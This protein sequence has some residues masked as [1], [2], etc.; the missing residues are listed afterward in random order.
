M[1]RKKIIATLGPSSLKK[2][3][4]EKMDF[5]GVDIFRLNLSHVPLNE[6]E[7]TL[8]MVT[9]WTKKTVC[10]DSEGAQLRTG[11][12]KEKK[13]NLIK[14]STI[15]IVGSNTN[16]GGS[17]IKLNLE[18][19]EEYLSVGDLLRIDFNSVVAQITKV[20][21]S[22]IFARIIKGGVI[23]SNKGIGLER[24]IMLPR[25][26]PKDISAFKICKKLGIDTF[27]LSFCSKGEDVLE[28]RKL[29]DYPIKSRHLLDLT[30]PLKHQK[31]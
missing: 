25:F 9:S 30:T 19:P 26:T 5:L 4:V 31:K 21:S 18:K 12:I 1:N 13:L 17:V 28:L 6:F 11:E 2:E 24:L 14:G 23:G 15:M 8:K 3:I 20:G 7:K 29:F 22:N 10:P 27:F 16:K